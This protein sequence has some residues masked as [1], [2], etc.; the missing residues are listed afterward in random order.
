MP[1]TRTTTETLFYF[2]ELSD[3]AKERAREWWREGFEFEFHADSVIDDAKECFK[4]VGFRVDKVFY[5]GFWSQGDGACFEGAFYASDFQPNKLSEYAPKDEELHRIEKEFAE[6]VKALPH[7]SFA[8]KHRGR[9]QHSFCTEFSIDFGQEED[10]QPSDWT[11]DNIKELARDCM[12]W[13]YSQLQKEYEY[14]TG[15]E[16]V[17]EAISANEYEFDEE[18]KR[19]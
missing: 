2:D 3:D 14:Q 13:T 16:Q 11:E 6:L 10:D 9:Y 7:M 8:V 18:G 19:K 17:D 5:S 4:L 15:D 12:D 1:H